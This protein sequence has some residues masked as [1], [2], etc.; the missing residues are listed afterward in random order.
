[1]KWLIENLIA[2]LDTKD[3][4]QEICKLN[5]EVRL[6]LAV[7][8]MNTTLGSYIIFRKCAAPSTNFF[9]ALNKAGGCITI[10]P[11]L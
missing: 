11:G 10:F 7:L 1:M 6:R 9:K 2:S 8:A 4:N 3:S 5:P